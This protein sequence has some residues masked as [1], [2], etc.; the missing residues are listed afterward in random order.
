MPELPEVETIV[1]GLNKKIKNRKIVGL[2]TDWPKYFKLHKNEKD[3][4]CHIVG[5]T[6][7]RVSRRAKNILFY[8]SD[9]HILLIHLKMTGHLLHGKWKKGVSKE[10][11]EKWRGEKWSPVSL[12][13]PLTDPFN[14]FIRVIFFLDKGMLALSDVRRFA[15]ILCGT[16]EEIFGLS[17]IKKLGPEPLDK[18]LTYDKFKEILKNKKG[19]IK[20]V[21]MDQ[22]VI[23]GIG[24][25]YSDEILWLSK[26]HPMRRVENLKRDE[27]KKI[28]KYIRQNLKK[29][30][31]FR[32]TSFNDYRDSEGKRG[33]YDVYRYVYQKES[34][35]CPRCGTKIKRI[36][37]GQRSAHFCPRCQ[38]L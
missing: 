8:L 20:K 27:L 37:V 2:W 24:N 28:Y 9:R 35:P 19:V 11:G 18:N 1:R 15:K 4:K 38:K 25:I 17:D 16:E 7:L 12:G 33:K 34:E 30:I 3:F 22:S 23:S 5:K 13:G 32:G 29:A 21:L 10:L 31:K 14:R 26:I 6:I 36:K